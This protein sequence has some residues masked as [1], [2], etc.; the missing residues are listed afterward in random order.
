MEMKALKEEKRK[1]PYP[2]Q[3]YNLWWILVCYCFGQISSGNFQSPIQSLTWS[4]REKQ[5][6]HHKGEHKEQAHGMEACTCETTHAF[7]C[8]MVSPGQL[9]TRYSLVELSSQCLFLKPS[10]LA[11]HNEGIC[12]KLCSSI[13]GNGSVIHNAHSKQHFKP[14]QHED[15]SF[16]H[17]L[18]RLLSC[19]PGVQS[20]SCSAFSPISRQT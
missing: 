7:K 10:I 4:E 20:S 13:K 17:P 12:R 14:K 6:W 16:I 19:L 11:G 2:S 18:L 9:K 3:F 1:P 15:F 8:S 5:W